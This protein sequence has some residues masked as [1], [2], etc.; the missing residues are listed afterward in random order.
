VEA[1]KATKNRFADQETQLGM[2][3]PYTAKIVRRHSQTSPR[4]E[5]QGKHDEERCLKR[6]K[7]LERPGQRRKLMPRIECGGGFLWNPYISRR[8]DGILLLLLLW[9][10]GWIS[11]LFQRWSLIALTKSMRTTHSLD[12]WSTTLFSTPKREIWCEGRIFSFVLQRF[13]HEILENTLSLI[14]DFGS[15]QKK[16]WR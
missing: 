8:N 5:P 12:I 4:V 6:P 1:Y 16:F 9:V 14:F 11:I 15:M 13:L 10:L 2:A 3:G 7:K